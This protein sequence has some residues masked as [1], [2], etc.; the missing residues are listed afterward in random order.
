MANPVLNTW[1]QTCQ[2]DA[3][4]QIFLTG[5]LNVEAYSSI[6]LEIV[7][8]ANAPMGITVSCTIGKISGNTLAQTVAQFPLAS[9]EEIHSFN[10]IGPE[11]SV[12]LTGGPANQGVPIQAWIFLH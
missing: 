6:N 10:V 4:G 12:V 9:T 2:T 1:F 5:P 11:F 8:G 3:Q 7:P